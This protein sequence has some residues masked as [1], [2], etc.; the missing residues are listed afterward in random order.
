MGRA[1]GRVD[2]D[3]AP[4]G[5]GGGRRYHAVDGWRHWTGDVRVANRRLGNRPTREKDDAPFSRVFCGRVVRTARGAA[6]S[7]KKKSSA[8]ERRGENSE[9]INDYVRLT[10][11]RC[12]WDGITFI[13]C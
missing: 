13:F 5:T 7:E 3:N 8:K 6:A 2:R 9:G 12:T 4:G 11:A 10:C 1:F